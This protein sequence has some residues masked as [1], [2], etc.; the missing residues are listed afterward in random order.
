MV[1][2][3]EA[4]GA[5]GQFQF[6]TNMVNIRV[7]SRSKNVSLMCEIK[8]INVRNFDNDKIDILVQDVNVYV[9]AV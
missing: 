7:E 5:G 9:T 6:G 1:M 2:D 4:G 8:S 3:L